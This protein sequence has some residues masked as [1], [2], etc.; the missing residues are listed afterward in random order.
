MF[1]TQ[2]TLSQWLEQ[3][4][5]QVSSGCVE[6]KKTIDTRGYGRLKQG[7]RSYS[8][9]R[10]SYELSYGYIPCGLCVCH[11]CDNPKCVNPAHLFLGTTLDNMRDRDIKNRRF[12]PRGVLHGRSS[13]N[14]RKVRLIRQFLERYPHA[15]KQ[16]GSPYPFLASWFGVTTAAIYSVH[17]RRTW[18]HVA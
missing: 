10:V 14:E 2:Q 4:A 5:V 17:V 11:K 9:H 3:N 16:L 8:A 18:K 12:T 1:T 15:R 7:G 6:W 13:L